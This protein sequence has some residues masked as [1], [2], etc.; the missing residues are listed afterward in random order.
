MTNNNFIL[1]RDAIV[2]EVVLNIPRSDELFKKHKIDFCCGGNRPLHEAITELGLEESPVLEALETLQ[3]EASNIQ[4]SDLQDWT[5]L[6]YS[7]LI[8]HIVHRHHGYLVEE[9][10][11]LSAYVT[12]IF[13]VHGTDHPELG[14]LHRLFHQLKMELEQHMMKEEQIIFP[15]IRHFEATNDDHD[16]SIAVSRIHELEAEHDEAGSLLKQIREVTS[17]FVLPPGACTTYRMTFQRLEALESDMFQHVHL[18]NN[19]MFP[20]LEA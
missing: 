11:D 1:N 10:P 5:N 14:E 20:R 6:S 7:S 16:K 13:R 3:N 12:K 15:A 9:L 8:D 17:D 18:E 19:I 4:V 2:R